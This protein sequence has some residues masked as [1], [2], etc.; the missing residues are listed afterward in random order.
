[1]WARLQKG[2]ILNILT[3]EENYKNNLTVQ[4]LFYMK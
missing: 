4:M 1:M 3:N 2:L